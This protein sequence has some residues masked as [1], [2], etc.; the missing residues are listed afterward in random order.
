MAARRNK[1]ENMLS[2]ILPKD[3]A[4]ITLDYYSNDSFRLYTIGGNYVDGSRM[5]YSKR[6]PYK[7]RYTHSLVDT[8][9]ERYL[10]T[11]SVSKYV[12]TE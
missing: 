11:S 9:V 7:S 10:C 6:P 2:E 12:K 3:P 1:L 4:R 5:S 8:D